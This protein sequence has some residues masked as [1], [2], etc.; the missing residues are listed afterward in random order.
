MV[1]KARTQ[2]ILL[3]QAFPPKTLCNHLRNK[4]EWA[5]ALLGRVHEFS[6]SS[7][8][9]VSSKYLG[10]NS[11]GNGGDLQGSVLRTGAGSFVLNLSSLSGSVLEEGIS[12]AGSNL[13]GIDC[14]T[15]GSYVAS[16]CFNRMSS[17]DDRLLNEAA[18]AGCLGLAI[19]HEGSMPLIR[20]YCASISFQKGGSHIAEKCMD[21]DRK[22]WVNEDFQSNTNT[23]LHVAK[24]VFGNYMIQKALKVTTQ[25]GSPFCQKF[26]PRLQLHFSFLQSGCGRNVYSLITDVSNVKSEE[27]F[28]F[29]PV[30]VS[31]VKS[32]ESSLFHIALD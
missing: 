23:L 19:D 6:S 16:E 31:N 3:L 1:L 5:P 7:I 21:T 4:D 28:K 24:D 12:R 10:S 20:G 27:S 15:M 11:L 9:N 8:P 25:S 13:R 18:I 2:C 26:M 30:D 22:S 14:S 29:I 32:E 17:E